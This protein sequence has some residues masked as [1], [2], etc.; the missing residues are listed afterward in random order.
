MTN[1]II[2]QYPRGSEWRKWDLHIHSKYSGEKRAKLKI[3]EIFEKSIKYGI[4]VISITDHNN[5]DGL[6]E[7]WQV[8]ETEKYNNKQIKEQI[9]FLPGV[10]IKTDSGKISVHVI[11][12]FPK[13]RDDNQKID[14]KYLQENFLNL[15]GF[16]EAKITKLGG[17]DPT[18]TNGVG[19]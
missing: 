1:S 12:V 9:E 17:G 18:P 8:W 13:Y 7:I 10:E 3:K 4:S 5:V 2:N 19:G 11:V 6:D 14:K 16:T 15:L